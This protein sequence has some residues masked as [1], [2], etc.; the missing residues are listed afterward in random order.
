LAFCQKIGA[1]SPVCGVLRRKCAKIPNRS[2]ITK[3]LNRLLAI[4]G[5]CG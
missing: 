5:F 2:E 4:A 1:K 3:I